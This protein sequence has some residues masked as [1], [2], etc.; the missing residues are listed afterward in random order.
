LP[1][2][3]HFRPTTDVEIS[4]MLANFNPKLLGMIYLLTYLF[5]KLFQKHLTEQQIDIYTINMDKND[6][7]RGRGSK[8]SDNCVVVGR[9][10]K[11]V[12]F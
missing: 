6:F 11:G 10:Q 1:T 3:F 2:K 5:I 9:G 8:F 12:T 7:R 4:N